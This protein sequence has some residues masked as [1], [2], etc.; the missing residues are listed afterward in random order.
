MLFTENETNFMK[1]WGVKNESQYVKDAFHERI[2]NG[3]IAAV[4]PRG[5]GTKC[6]AWYHFPNVPAGQSVVV[7]FKLTNKIHNNGI[8]DE[9]EFDNTI[10][11]RKAEA[12]AFYAQ[13]AN[14]PISDDMRNIQ[15]QAFAGMLWSKQYYHFVYKRWIEGDENR[16]PPPLERKNVRNKGWD[17]MYIDDILSMVPPR[18]EMSSDAFSLINGSIRS[19]RLGIVHSTVSPS[20]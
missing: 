16:P 4:N 3:N 10:S 19:L 13:V 12:N 8:L 1:I 7:R 2:V 14:V 11:A 20:R 17:H 18:A 6:G 15:R 5:L 9:E